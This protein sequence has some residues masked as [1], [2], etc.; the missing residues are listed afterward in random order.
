M[1]V[2]KIGTAVTVSGMTT[3]FGF[4]ALLL[5]T[6]NIVKNFGVVTVI[7]V[8]FSLIGA[9]IVMPAVLSL[10]GTLGDRKTAQQASPSE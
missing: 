7:T 6:F 5:S 9:I 3:V 8:G 10:M 4:S 2:Q 1:S